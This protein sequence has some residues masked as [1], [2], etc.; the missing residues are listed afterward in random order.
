MKTKNPI[1]KRE[2]ARRLIVTNNMIKQL[3]ETQKNIKVTGERLG[4]LKQDLEWELITARIKV[5]EAKT[6]A[7]TEKQLRLAGQELINARSE[8]EEVKVN[9]SNLEITMENVKEQINSKNLLEEAEK[10]A[11]ATL[12]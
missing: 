2:W 12:N 11:N 4:M 5:I 6:Y 9:Y 3:R 1:K 10:L 8:A 7:E